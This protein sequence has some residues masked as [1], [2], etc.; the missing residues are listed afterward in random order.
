MPERVSIVPMLK[1][2]ARIPGWAWR[3]L[4]RASSWVVVKQRRTAVRQ[5]RLNVEVAIGRPPTDLETRQAIFSW[6]RNLAGSV[7]LSRLTRNQVLAQVLCEPDDL[8]R[9]RDAFNGP[10]AIVALPHMGDWDL[11][12]AWAGALGMPV[13]SVAERLADEEF[14]YFM[15]VRSRV[16][17]RIYAHND[18]GSTRKLIDDL[19]E[20]RVV[21]LVADRD[22][23]RNG[24]PVHWNTPS[25]PRD[26][27]LSPGPA[28]MARSTGATLLGAVSTFEDNKMRLVFDPIEVDRGEDGIRVTTQRLADYF[29]AAVQAKPTDW[30]LMQRFF[31]GVTA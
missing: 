10:G 13:S 25:G 30:H 6:Y 9:F 28:H 2:A 7:Q 22:M 3:P 18:P 15:A 16:G 23:S 31:P 5:W 8:Q 24:I 20:R 4:V 21:A 19:A 12:G 14:T 11:A 1:I 17:M 27:T 26:V 29:S